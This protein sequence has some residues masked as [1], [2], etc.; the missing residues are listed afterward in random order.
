MLGEGRYLQASRTIREA[1]EGISD[2]GGHLVEQ[3]VVWGV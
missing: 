3:R 2:P 1:P